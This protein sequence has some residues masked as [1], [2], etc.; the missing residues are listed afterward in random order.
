MLPSIFISH[1][2]PSL[3]LGDSPARSFL[4]SLT[5]LLPFRPPATLIISAHWEESVVTLTGLDPPTTIHDF[6]GF[7]DALSERR[8]LA[9]GS[10]HLLHRV[11]SEERLVGTEV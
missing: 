1:G 7:P 9:Q 10:A 6:G 3:A 5:A 8:N 11:N 2:A 4:E